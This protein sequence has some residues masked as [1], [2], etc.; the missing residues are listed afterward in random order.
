MFAL[1]TPE[2]YISRSLS[3]QILAERHARSGDQAMARI[4]RKI[5]DQFRE[6]AV[7]LSVGGAAA[8]MAVWGGS[9]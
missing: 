5:S 6:T 3:A 8:E 1:R 2:S 9:L 4:W 7:K